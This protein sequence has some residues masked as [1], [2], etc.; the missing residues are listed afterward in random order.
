MEDNLRALVWRG[1]ALF[2]K[3]V[4]GESSAWV[5]SVIALGLL[6]RKPI[7]RAIGGV[8][9]V[10]EPSRTACSKHAPRAGAL[11]KIFAPRTMGSP[12]GHAVGFLV[13][14]VRVDFRLRSSDTDFGPHVPTHT[15]VGCHVDHGIAGL[16]EA[17][18]S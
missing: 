2:G 12:F 7:R 3:L 11:G 1:P 18:S 14:S 15:D 5:S 13:A 4:C 16:S 9:G 6:L 10:D 8:Y 17:T